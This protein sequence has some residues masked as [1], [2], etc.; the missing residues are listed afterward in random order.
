MNSIWRQSQ[1]TIQLLADAE[2][3]NDEARN[4]LM[5]RHRD[6]LRQMVNMRMDRKLKTRIDASDIVQD[7]L[8]EAN[9]RLDDFISADGM[10]FHL[11]L[12][13]LAKDRIIDMHRR[14]RR[15]SKRSVDKEQRLNVGG[16]GDRSSLELAAQLRDPE[17]TPAAA[18]LRNELEERFRAAVEELN[19][20]D[21]D[22][23]LMRNFEHLSNTEV[24]EALNLSQPAAGMR[25]LRALK[26]LRKVLGDAEIG[27]DEI[28]DSEG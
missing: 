12:R 2:Q 5:E 4:Q 22:I 18:T 14:H 1:E 10:P 6:S 27:D 19:E 24:A 23:I 16:F 20:D 21:R 17:L 25:Y 3:G 28:V 13:Q 15:A 8:I 9:R 11:W 7:V 26:R